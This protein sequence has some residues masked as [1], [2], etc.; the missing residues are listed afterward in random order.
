MSSG[1]KTNTN[2]SETEIDRFVYVEQTYLILFYYFKSFGVDHSSGNRC[3]LG[4]YDG[5][6]TD[7]GRRSAPLA[8]L[9]TV[10]HRSRDSWPTASVPNVTLSSIQVSRE[11]CTAGRVSLRLAK[12]CKTQQKPV[13]ASLTCDSNR[14]NNVLYI[15]IS[16]KKKKKRLV[17]ETFSYYLT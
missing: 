5:K 6:T 17:H 13:H 12:M 9:V 11:Y 2:G 8:L 3:T 14:E 7:E 10:D 15:Y 16:F 4:L 1:T